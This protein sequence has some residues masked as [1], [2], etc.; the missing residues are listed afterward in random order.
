MFKSMILNVTK[1]T[2]TLSKSL[3]N[4]L[5]HA[6]HTY[7]PCKERQKGL[8]LDISI[9]LEKVKDIKKV[10]PKRDTKERF[11]AYLS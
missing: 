8:G 7:S 9:K 5:K 1:M 2:L 4:N 11:E 10:N 6:Y 3:P